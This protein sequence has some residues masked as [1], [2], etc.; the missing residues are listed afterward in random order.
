M[1][2]LLDTVPVEN[3]IHISG[4]QA[5]DFI[6]GRMNLPTRPIRIKVE[7]GYEEPALEVLEPLIELLVD[8]RSYCDRNGRMMRRFSLSVH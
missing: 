4:Q 6:A 1:H 2:D 3:Q 8:R 5:D 7:R